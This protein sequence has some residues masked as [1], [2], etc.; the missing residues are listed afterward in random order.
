MTTE[1]SR[2][3]RRDEEARVQNSN[4]DSD[5]ARK[6]ASRF[7]MKEEESRCNVS[8]LDLPLHQVESTIT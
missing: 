2:Y 3:L 1:F 8:G 5:V 4:P 7:W 6:K